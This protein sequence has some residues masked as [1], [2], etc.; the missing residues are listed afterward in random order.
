MF[1]PAS[2][3][4]IKATPVCDAPSRRT[5]SGRMPSFARLAAAWSPK[6][7]CPSLTTIVTSASNRA[8]ATAW[9]APLPPGPVMNGPPRMVSPLTGILGVRISRSMLKLPTTV[10]F[11]LVVI[12][13]NSVYR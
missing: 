2:S 8:A 1:S 13:V 9:F 3:T 7:S 10:T 12:T 4:T 6:A 11:A 5:K